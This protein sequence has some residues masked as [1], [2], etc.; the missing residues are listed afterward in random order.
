MRSFPAPVDATF[1]LIL[2]LA[3]LVLCPISFSVN[4]LSSSPGG[5][6]NYPLVSPVVISLTLKC[7]DIL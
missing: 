2:F 4:Q 1:L 3:L 5:G 6:S 7:A